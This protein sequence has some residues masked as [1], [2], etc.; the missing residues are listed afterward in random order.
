MNHDNQRSDIASDV[1]IKMKVRR[2]GILGVDGK[3]LEGYL[4]VCANEKKTFE[5][6]SEIGGGLRRFKSA[7]K[8]FIKALEV[9]PGG[10]SGPPK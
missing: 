9:N 10:E 7:F 5:I 2:V 8:I 4:A 3:F 6:Q 1:F